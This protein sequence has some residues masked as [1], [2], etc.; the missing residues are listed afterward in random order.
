M[1]QPRK[2][3]LL[4]FPGIGLA[5]FQHVA[6]VIRFD[7]DRGAAPQSLADQS[8][9]MSEV[10]QRRDLDAGVSGGETE[11]IDRIMRNGERMKI[12]FADAKVVTRLDLFDAIAQRRIAPS[13]LVRT[14]AEALADI[15]RPRF[16][17]D[18]YRAIH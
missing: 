1:S 12:D 16:G 2:N 17:R 3:A 15:R 10:H 5:G 6:T 18:E 7:H 4:Q 9:D 13:R 11:V 14:D 8:R